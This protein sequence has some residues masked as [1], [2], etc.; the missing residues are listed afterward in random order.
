MVVWVFIL[1]WKCWWCKLKMGRLKNF[2][3]FLLDWIF[4]LLVYN[5]CI[6]IVLD[7]LIMCL[8]LM[9]KFLKFL[10][11]CVCMKGLFW[12]WNFFMFWFMCWKWCVKIWIKSSYWWLIF[13]VVVIKIFLLFM[14]FW[15]YE[16]KFDGMLWIFVCLVEGV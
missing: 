9:M 12:C 8:L 14:I 4:C 3:L 11:C 15:K 2:I 7:V 6:L 1:V 13:L 16:G 10:K 5:M